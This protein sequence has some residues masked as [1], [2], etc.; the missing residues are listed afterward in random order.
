M[1]IA[2]FA[3]TFFPAVDGVVTSMVSVAREMNRLGH[4]V[5]FF[6][7]RP[8]HAQAARELAPGLDI[9]FVRSVGFFTYSTYRISAPLSL[10]TRRQLDS[11]HPDVIHVHTPFSLGWIGARYAKKKKIPLVGTYHTLLPEF[12]MY[13]PLPVI[14][15]SNA[16]KEM[17]WKYSRF[18]YNRCD[19]ITTPTQEMADEL[20]SH[21]IPAVCLSNPIRFRLFNKYAKTKKESVFSLVFFGRLSFEKNIDVVL[22]TVRILLDQKKKVRLVVIGTGPAESFLKKKAKEL[23]I[24]DHV[25]FRGVLRDDDLAKAVAKTHCVMTA[26]TMETQGMTILEAM[27]AGVP[28]VGANARAIPATV[29]KGVNGY[30]F[31]PGNSK[32]AADLISTIMDSHSLQEKLSHNSIEWAKRFSEESIVKQ[33]FELYSDLG[34][35]PVVAAGKR[36]IHNQ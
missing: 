35:K 8:K 29:K 32:Q 16:A 12:L 26:A 15:R 2:F 21:R 27:S 17:A 30:L 23:R 22:E 11:F 3:D 20:A 18:F 6:V 19:V 4:E 34:S 28:C 33:Y 13:V 24:A 7:P 36:K 5:R 14:N 1:K 25:D 10:S 9:H 31:E